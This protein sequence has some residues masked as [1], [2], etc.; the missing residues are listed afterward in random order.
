MLRRQVYQPLDLE[1]Q[2]HFLF[3]EPKNN[4]VLSQRPAPFPLPPQWRKGHFHAAQGCEEKTVPGRG[5]RGKSKVCALLRAKRSN[6]FLSSGVF[7][8]RIL[9]AAKE[10]FRSHFFWGWG[11]GVG[12]GCGGLNGK[13]GERTGQVKGSSEKTHCPGRWASSP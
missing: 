8:L 10:R 3:P 1:G 2:P 4:K 13:H 6:A 11:R 12:A 9:S 5:L 7:F